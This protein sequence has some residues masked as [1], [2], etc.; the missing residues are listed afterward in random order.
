MLKSG[1]E[2][3]FY[4]QTIEDC[5]KEGF[6]DFYMNLASDK[7]VICESPA[8]IRYFTPGLFI[9]MISSAGSTMKNMEYINM[10]PHLEFTY[11]EVLKT[12]NLPVGF[13]ENGWNGI[14]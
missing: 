2:R 7:P 5:L 8:L 6:S 11:E 10:Y 9:I 1:A 3:V 14:E 12:K 4:I 13:T